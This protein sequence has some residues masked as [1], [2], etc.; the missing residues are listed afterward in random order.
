MRL[1]KHDKHLHGHL[2]LDYK[3]KILTNFTLKWCNFELFHV[4]LVVINTQTSPHL[5]VLLLHVSA[6]SRRQLSADQLKINSRDGIRP[7]AD[8]STDHK[9]NQ[10]GDEVQGE[11][12]RLNTGERKES[13]TNREQGGTLG[14]GWRP[15]RH[16]KHGTDRAATLKHSTTRSNLH[17]KR[18]EWGGAWANAGFQSNYPNDADLHWSELNCCS[19]CGA[20]S[21]RSR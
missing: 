4:F 15:G 6:E 17:V 11:R 13:D 8:D 21:S 20:L 10:P 14:A 9:L 1:T 2:T 19:T 12:V 3:K 5:P 16:M 7:T 18:R